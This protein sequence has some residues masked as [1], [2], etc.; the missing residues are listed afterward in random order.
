[1][2]QLLHVDVLD[3]D[4]AVAEHVHGGLGLFEDYVAERWIGVIVGFFGLEEDHLVPHG[5]ESLDL[6]LDGAAG[7]TKCLRVETTANVPDFQAVD[8]PGTDS[9][10]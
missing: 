6:D 8:Q 5:A 10:R 1:M 2:G 7:L 9:S 3:R 4:E